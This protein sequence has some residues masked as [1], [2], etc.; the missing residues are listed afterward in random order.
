MG[1]N[2]TDTS[3]KERE[4]RRK[5]YKFALVRWLDWEGD[6]YA[7]EYKSILGYS[8][9]SHHEVLCDDQPERVLRAMKRMMEDKDG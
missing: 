8:W 6:N 9:Y 1:N 7:V 2:V 5:K 3:D 4:R